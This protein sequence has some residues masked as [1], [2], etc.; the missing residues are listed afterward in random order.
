MRNKKL[1]PFESIEKAVAGEPEA[2]DAVLRHYSGDKGIGKGFILPPL[3]MAFYCVTWQTI[4]CI[5]AS[6]PFFSVPAALPLYL[7]PKERD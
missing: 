2:I 3:K 1:I 6:V 4:F 5:V 7:A